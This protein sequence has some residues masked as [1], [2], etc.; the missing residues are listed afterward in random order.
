MH[1]SLCMPNGKALL[2][3]LIAMVAKGNNKPNAYIKLDKATTQ[4]LKDWHALLKT[5][6]ARPTPCKDLAPADPDYGRYCDASKMGAGGVWFGISKPLP[7]IVWRITFPP[8][9][10][11]AIVSE[12]NPTGRLTNSDLEMAG[13]LCQWLVLEVMAEVA[14]THV[15]IGCDNTP[16]VAWSSRLLATKAPI[17]AHLLRALAL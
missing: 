1:A 5:A 13:M 14:H 17:A 7:P 4:A 11:Q 2:S 16:T 9:I 8:D 12:S 3:P 6:A 10:Q 15:A